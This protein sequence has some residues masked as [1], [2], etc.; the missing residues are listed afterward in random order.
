SSLHTTAA[1]AAVAVNV[2]A[3]APIRRVLRI[4][5]MVDS[6]IVSPARKT[7]RRGVGFLQNR[8]RYLF[9]TVT[10]RI[11]R[12]CIGPPYATRKLAFPICGGCTARYGCA[13][14]L[15]GFGRSPP[16]HSARN[17][18]PLLRALTVLGRAFGGYSLHFGAIP[19][20]C[21]RPTRDETP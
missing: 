15:S 18:G 14:A 7:P 3:P 1:D 2:N 13:H 12:V 20:C 19:L 17:P 16:T 8:R 6:T 21:W 4:A 11:L 5:F 10:F 9:A